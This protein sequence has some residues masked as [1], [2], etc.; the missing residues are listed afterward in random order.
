MSE[1]KL[2]LNISVLDSY[3]SRYDGQ[4]LAQL[5]LTSSQAKVLYF[6]VANI[7]REIC[8]KNIN[9]CFGVT[10]ATSSGILRRLINKGYVAE[11]VDKQDRRRKIFMITNSGLAV[12]G[13][14]E[15]RFSAEKDIFTAGL[16]VAELN[17]FELVLR[18][19][20]SNISK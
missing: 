20:I 16:T 3:I 10:H 1:T 8:Q 6:L 18:K 5:N 17:S 12:Y 2:R 11:T 13:M 9:S 15:K 19:M 14:F 4:I 7:D